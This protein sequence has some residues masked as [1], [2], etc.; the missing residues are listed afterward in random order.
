ML[1]RM[2]TLATVLKARR[3]ELCGLRWSDIDWSDEMLTIERSIVPMTGGQQ[4]RTTKTGKA[5]SIPIP[6]AVEVFRYQHQRKVEIFGAVL[7]DGYIF[8]SDD[9][10]T[11][12]RAKSVTEFFSKHA[13]RAGVAARFHDLRHFAVSRAI[14]NGWDV[15]TAGNYFGHTPQVMLSIYSHGTIEDARAAAKALPPI[16]NR[17]TQ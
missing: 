8:G 16:A 10:T 15:T 5:R 9:G 2:K 12:P 17:G 1:R 6:Q 7:V 11:P 3:D 14:A 4:V 13:K